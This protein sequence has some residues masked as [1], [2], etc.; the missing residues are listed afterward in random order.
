MTRASEG[1]DHGSF[2]PQEEKI[3]T[4]QTVKPAGQP[5]PPYPGF[6]MRRAF[7]TDADAI[8]WLEPL[9]FSVGRQQAHAPRGVL[10][11]D[12]DI[13]KW[14]NLRPDD[15]DDLHGTL[16][17]SVVKIWNSAPAAARAAIARAT[18][19]PR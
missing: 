14:R 7:A 2:S 6:F 4:E 13:Q 5:L 10:F 12:Y 16:V 19:E 11:G 18:G 8:A 3:P 1:Q 9:G 17:N 15:V